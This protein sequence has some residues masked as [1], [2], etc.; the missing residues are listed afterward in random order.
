ME[1]RKTEHTPPGSPKQ[2][3]EDCRDPLKPPPCQGCSSFSRRVS[4]RE[5]YQIDGRRNAGEILC[6][7]CIRPFVGRDS[8]FV[9]VTAQAVSIQPERYMAFLKIV[10]IFY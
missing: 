9:L 10:E 2:D 7:L 5:Y 1:G 8:E 3:A 4:G 6:D